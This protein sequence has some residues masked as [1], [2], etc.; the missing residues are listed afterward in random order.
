MAGFYSSLRLWPRGSQGIW[1]CSGT[2]SPTAVRNFHVSDS[3]SQL[4]NSCTLH[5]CFVFYCGVVCDSSVCDSSRFAVWVGGTMDHSGAG[6]E[7][8]PYWL[9][10]MVPLTAHLNASNSKLPVDINAQVNH[11][12][13]YILEHQ[14]PNGWLGPDD[15]FGE[16]SPSFLLLTSLKGGKGNTY[17]TGWNVAASLLQFAN[18]S[19]VTADVSAACNKAVLDYITEVHRRMLTMPTTSWSQNRWQDWALIVMWMLDQAPQGQV[20]LGLQA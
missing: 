13:Q 3:G 4:W 18:S 17:W 20:N 19:F 10:G 9:N 7:R 5:I 6:H 1:T 16:V 2:M 12:V 11:W 8:G 15:G 14:L